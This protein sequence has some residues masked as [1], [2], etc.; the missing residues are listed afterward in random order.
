MRPS[1]RLACL[2]E[3]AVIYVFTH[4][5]I[6]L[7]EDGPTHQPVEHLAALRAIPNMTVIRPGDAHETAIAWQAAMLN[8]HGPTALILSRQNVATLD[9]STH[10]SAEGLLKGAY[11]LWESGGVP[12]V[13]IIGTGSELE[14][15]LSAGKAL[16]DSGSAVRV[17]SM[18]CWELFAAQP[19][20]YRDS[21]LPPA[22]S[23]R[24]AVEAASPFGWERWIGTGGRFIGMHGFG[25]SAPSEE[26]YPH[27]GITVDKVV[28]AARELLGA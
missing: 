3:Q 7:G 24:V 1:I 10:A 18:P 4:D 15:A 17:V 27:F 9:R 13:I 25:A 11:T 16:A 20:S 21:V 5:S 8:A 28:A 14:L 6:G 22:V 2:M 19:Q 12:A 23:A 26:L